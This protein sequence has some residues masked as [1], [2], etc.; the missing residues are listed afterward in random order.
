[1]S[2]KN[3]YVKLTEEKRKE[4]EAA[5]CTNSRPIFRQRCHY[6]L[7]SD[8]GHTIKSITATYGICRQVVYKWFDKYESLGID[9]LATK[10]GQGNKPILRLDNEQHIDLVKSLVNEH[11]QNLEPVLA[12][13]EMELG[14]PLSKRTLTRFLKKL[15]TV[16]SVFGESP[17]GSQ[18]NKSTKPNASNSSF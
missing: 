10:E 4:L 11:P 5:F 8:Q 14:K 17:R 15:A 18:M 3:R 12:K 9:G 1:M 13:L 6:I 16:G 7:L 2:R